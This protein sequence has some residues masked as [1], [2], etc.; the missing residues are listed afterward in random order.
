MKNEYDLAT[1]LEE[2]SERQPAEFNECKD[3]GGF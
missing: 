1:V 2:S 3:M